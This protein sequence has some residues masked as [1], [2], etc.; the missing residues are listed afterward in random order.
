LGEVG[1]GWSGLAGVA[2]GDKGDQGQG[3]CREHR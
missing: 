3:C 1:G 2:A